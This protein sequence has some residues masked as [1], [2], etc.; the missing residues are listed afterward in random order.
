MSRSDHEQLETLLRRCRPAEPSA[1][2]KTHVLTAAETAWR[3]HP[4]ESA[5]WR[6]AAWRL[7]GSVAAAVLVVFSA[8]WGSDWALSRWQPSPGRVCIQ[9]K[10]APGD[11]NENDDLPW[12]RLARINVIISPPED[13]LD[14]LLWYRQSMQRLFEEEMDRVPVRQEGQRQGRMD[15]MGT[16]A[17]TL[18]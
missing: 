18:S 8:G 12:R 4:A 11:L 7:A 10:S 5:S 13:T 6:I 3:E 16:P 2:L 9:M 15:L 17:W 1:G 14:Q